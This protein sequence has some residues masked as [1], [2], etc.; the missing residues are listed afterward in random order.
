MLKFNLI[1]AMCENHGM[2][3]NNTLPWRLK[4]EMEYFT[5][6]TS[7]TVSDSKENVVVMGR[8]TWDSIPHKYK[9]LANRINFV[10]SRSDLDLQKYNNVYGFKSW[11]E[12]EKKL[13][14]K[15][16]SDAYEKIWIIGGAGIYK[17][18]LESKHFYRLYLTEIKEDFDCDIFFPQFTN[19]KLVRDSLAPIGIQ[20]EGNIEYEFMVYENQLASE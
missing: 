17:D 15:L 7:T 13:T 6:M 10:L 9:P 19:V 20:K 2:G 3:K 16:F 14:D 5:R 11:D 8:K 1:A 4:K 18:A 12:I